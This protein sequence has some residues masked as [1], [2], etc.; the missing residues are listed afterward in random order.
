MMTHTTTSQGSLAPTHD[1]AT[2]TGPIIAAVGGVDPE[3]VLRAAR[4]LAPASAGVVAVA[5]LGWPSMG[6]LDETLWTIPSYEEDR[7]ADCTADLV[8]RLDAFGGAAASWPR[9][10]VRGAPALAL[11][12][13]ARAQHASM[14]IVGIGRHRPLDRIF[15]A[16]TA[17]RI[18][19]RTPCPVLVV[20]PE[21]DGP[22]HDAVIATDFSPASAA[23]ARAVIPLLSPV[24]TVHVVHVWEPDATNDARH[25]AA[26]DAYARALPERFRRFTG[27][28]EMPSGVTVKTV[29]RDGRAAERLLGYAAAHHADVVVAG[30]HGHGLLQRLLVG[31]Q[32][33]ALLRAADRSLLIAPEPPLA[34]RDL[35]RRT[36]TGVTRSS[37]PAEWEEQLHAL[38]LRNHGRPT[39]VE[40]DDRMFGAQVVE[41]GYLLLGADYDAK[42]R[43]IELTFGDAAQGTRRVTRAIG[44]V[45][46]VTIESDAAGRDVGLRISHGGGQ[47]AL[48]FAEG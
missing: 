39:V 37:D 22:F 24:A 26:A 3:S 35:L 17:L 33:T 36:L 40:V 47:T 21:F 16:E 31:S 23:A 19:Q 34:E 1:G 7:F 29:T 32:T 25:A 43:R 18:I 2:T 4:V 46:S 20:H 6:I 38:S 30:R 10:V 15:G 48:T 42:A 44:A 12:E 41:S 14:L 9:K 5:V 8:A 45:D 27:L 13:L 11:T 28:L